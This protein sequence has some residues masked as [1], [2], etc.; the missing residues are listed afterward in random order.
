MKTFITLAGASALMVGSAHAVSVFQ[1]S[2]TNTTK[3]S[4]NNNAGD[5]LDNIAITGDTAASTLL[6]SNTNG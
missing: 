2:D 6:I 3:I 1:A 5:S 4:N